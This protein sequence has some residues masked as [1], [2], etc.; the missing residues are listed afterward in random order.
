MVKSIMSELK[1]GD[2]ISEPPAIILQQVQLENQS[3]F[4]I[5]NNS[6]YDSISKRA[7]FKQLSCNGIIL[8]YYVA[9]LNRF[10]LQEDI[11]ENFDEYK[12]YAVHLDLIYILPQ[13]RNRSFGKATMQRFLVH[14]RNV[15]AHTGCRFVTLDALKGLEE[16]YTSIGFVNTKIEGN[17][18][19][20]TKM[21]IDMRNKAM[22]DSFAEFP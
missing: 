1:I 3:F 7:A 14:A 2:V 12:Y 13:Y 5:L 20:T 11:I 19:A 16:W 8:G 21:F 22:Y 6:Y 18:G 17:S 9:S 10:S 4:N 15:S